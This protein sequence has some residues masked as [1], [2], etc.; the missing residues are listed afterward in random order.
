VRPFDPRL[1]RHARATRGLLVLLGVLGAAQVLLA[2]GLAYVIAVVVTD[3]FQDGRTVADEAEWLAALLLVLLARA[4]IGYVQDLVS[5]RTSA[6]V[7]SELSARVVQQVAALGPSW[8]GAVRGST[9]VTLLTSGL[10]AL[11]E[12]FGSYVPQL[13]YT[14]IIPV[15]VVVVVFAAD[16]LSGIIIAVT[17][18]LIPFFMVLIGWRTQAE[19]RRQWD[20]L[21]TLSGHFLDVLRG[22]VTLKV[23]G[24][25]A[26]QARAIEEVGDTYRRRTMR[27]L[28]IS[29]LSSLTLEL[30]ATLSVAIVAVEVGLRLIGGS[31]DLRTGLFVLVLAPEA[32]L[33]LRQVGV[34]YHA[35][36]AGL[37]AAEEVFTILEEPAPPSPDEVVD[38]ASN[39]LVLDEV[40]VRY[41]DRTKDALQLSMRVEPGETVAL[42]GPSGGGKS[43]A[44]AVMIGAVTPTGGQVRA[45]A[46]DEPARWRS[47][48]AWM[49][50]HPGF[51]Q[52]SIADNV[53]LVAPAATDDEVR[54]ALAAAGADFVDDL[55]DGIRTQ[56]G[57]SGEGLSVGQRQRVAL[58]RVF[59]RD[60][61]VVAVD[62]PTA[63]LDG[64]TE[65]AVAAAIT[66]LARTRS[67]L[68]VAHRPALAAGA[69][70]TVVVM[71]GPGSSR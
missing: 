38:L 68:M 70:R 30:L 5:A 40:E 3:V 12:Y 61:P 14:A 53:R 29:F 60:T 54:D 10:D 58:A 43:T 2:I 57:E 1:L 63:G 66:E 9:V 64:G 20:A 41:P 24:R 67:V 71:P 59:V 33:P 51:V 55:V 39:P 46:L 7:K 23:F 13:V 34:H 52:G 11:D 42:V 37:A 15:T 18:P 8:L 69:D 16:P 28:R 17:L 4:V 50:Q 31:L 49:P 36:Q 56:L 19:Q 22:L 27:V 25:A 26:G 65:R 32:Y 45:G 35:S 21:Q 6:R 47:Q 44:L 48:I 62:E